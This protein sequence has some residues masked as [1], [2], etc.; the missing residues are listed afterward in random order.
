[1]SGRDRLV[2]IVPIGDID[3]IRASFEHLVGAGEQ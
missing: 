1:M 3:S 2:W